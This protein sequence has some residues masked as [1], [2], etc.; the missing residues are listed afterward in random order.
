MICKSTF[1]TDGGPLATSRAQR[2]ITNELKVPPGGIFSYGCEIQNWSSINT[3]VKIIYNKKDRGRYYHYIIGFDPADKVNEQKALKIGKEIA[4]YWDNRYVIDA[5]HNNTGHIHLHFL[6]SYTT[7][8][9]KQKGMGGNDLN[10]LKCFISRIAETEG[11]CKVRMYNNTVQKHTGSITDCDTD[12][13]EF[14]I[15]DT[16]YLSDPQEM[17]GDI[18]YDMASEMRNKQ[19]DRQVINRCYTTNNFYIFQAP[20]TFNQAGRYGYGYYNRANQQYPALTG[21]AGNA[22]A[23]NYAPAGSIPLLPAAQSASVLRRL[24]WKIRN[25]Q[26]VLLLGIVILFHTITLLNTGLM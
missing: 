7:I 12:D 9:G 14:E 13:P 25:P 2:Y 6:V 23:I 8:D 26:V 21:S 10:D 11:C 17:F 4:P 24:R 22:A 20:T 18:T 1:C 16:E 3:A 19:S 15:P 5:V